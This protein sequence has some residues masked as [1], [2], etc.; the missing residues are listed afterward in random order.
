MGK[1]FLLPRPFPT[2][3][4]PTPPFFGSTVSD[5][6]TGTVRGVDSKPF[7]LVILCPFL[8]FSV[9]RPTRVTDSGSP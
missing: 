6:V 4:S 9:R 1:S 5:K 7:S 8:G 2:L 3:V